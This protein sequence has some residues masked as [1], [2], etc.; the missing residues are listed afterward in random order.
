MIYCLWYPSGGYGHFVN[1]ILGFY[2]HDFARPTNSFQVSTD[3][4]CHDIDL[5]IP[6]YNS[7]SANNYQLPILSPDKNYSVLIDNGINDETA[8]FLCC[9]DGAKVIKICYDDW[10][11]P[12]VAKTHVIKAMH[13]EFDQ[14]L[15]PDA[16]RWPDSSDWAVREKFF[17]YLR[18]HD[19]RSKWR[20][21]Q[22]R[23]ISI[24]HLRDHDTLIAAIRS[25]GIAI[26]NF[27]ATWHTWWQKNQIYF[28]PII[29][30]EQTVQQVKLRQ[31]VDLAH[32][33]D[34]WTQAVI[35]YYIW[36]HWRREVPHN[37]YA[38]FFASTD[39]ILAWLDL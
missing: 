12:V 8:D 32:V 28:D 2:G 35:Y 27:T 23:S 10:T 6:K 38:G 30:A 11:W 17:L 7:Q 33:T 29:C 9:F 14:H 3:G 34:F 26:D 20:P 21:E 25:C 39:E 18:D 13:S 5:V 37:D 36:L 16:H 31:S 19:L 4:N 1:A 15:S 24:D 22:Y